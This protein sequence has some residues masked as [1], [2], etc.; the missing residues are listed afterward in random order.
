MRAN[1]K[2]IFE[3]FDTDSKAGSQPVCDQSRTDVSAL[4]NEVADSRN[5]ATTEKNGF[6][7]DGSYKIAESLPRGL[8]SNAL[9]D[10]SGTLAEPVVLTI[11]FSALVTSNGITLHFPPGDYPSQVNMQWYNGNN[12]LYETLRSPDS[13]MYFIRAN[14]ENYDRL[15]ITFYGTVQPGHYIKLT[16]IDY[17]QKI[18]FFGSD[19]IIKSKALQEIDLLCDEIAINTLEFTVEDK[20]RLFSVVSDNSVFFAVQENQKIT[21]YT[22]IGGNTCHIGTYYLQD[23]TGSGITANFKAQDA[24]GLLDGEEDVPEKYYD[25][26]FENFCADVLGDSNYIIDQ[27]LKNQRIKGYLTPCSRRQALQQACFAAGA[28]ADT[29]GGDRIRFYPLTE[30]PAQLLTASGIFAGGKVENIKPCRAISITAHNFDTDGIDVSSVHT[31]IINPK[32]KGTVSVEDARFVNEDNVESVLD[33]LQSYYQH[34]VQYK[35][36]L[37]L[38]TLFNMGDML[39][40]Y[41]ENSYIKGNLSQMDINLS[42]GLTADII[43]AGYVFDNQNGTFTG[44]IYAG[45]RGVL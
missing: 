2:I 39:M 43:M 30:K 25:T 34:R 1:T 6:F 37:P 18:T 24:I 31:R 20:D 7:L 5:Y 27:S 32:A 28:V 15:I 13:E 41:L 26:S 44:E 14:V 8:Y 36:S 17:G 12:L 9:S 45:E 16:G 35:V 11:T 3:M 4:K 40:I 23:I 10:D 33:R 21:V 29:Q 19:K 42:G 38:D 22:D